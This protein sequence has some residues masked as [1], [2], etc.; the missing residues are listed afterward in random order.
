M[1][2]R[3]NPRLYNDQINEVR[4]LRPLPVTPVKQKRSVISRALYPLIMVAAYGF[5]VLFQSDISDNAFIPS[6]NANSRIGST[7]YRG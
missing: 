7:C 1:E 2:F 4:P 3:R 5:D 6:D